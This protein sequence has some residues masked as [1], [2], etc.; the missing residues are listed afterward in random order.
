MAGDDF[1]DN[2]EAD[3]CALPARFGGKE[4][5]QHATG[6]CRRDARAVI[7]NG[8]NQSS[9]SISRAR[10]NGD[11]SVVSTG[12]AGIEHEVYDRMFKQA[13]IP[14]DDGEIGCHFNQQ[15]YASFGEAMFDE[16]Y[17]PGDQ[18]RGLNGFGGGPIAAGKTKQSANDSVNA[19]NL[20]KND[21]NTPRRTFVIREFGD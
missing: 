7:D 21:A 6:V 18:G 12:I 13:R 11:G 4:G 20:F 5:F 8:N 3:A 2:G 17:C 10:K 15:P 9:I 14:V 19:V 16:R 1:L